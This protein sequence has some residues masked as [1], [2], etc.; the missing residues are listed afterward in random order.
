MIIWRP[1]SIGSLSTFAISWVSCFTRSKSRRP[2]SWLGDLTAAEAEGDLDLVAFLEEPLNGLH[3]HFV[4]VLVDAGTELDLLH[5]D[6]LLPLA[7]L[8]LL[9]LFVEAE[10]PVIKE[11]AD[12]RDRIRRDF[13]EVEADLLSHGQRVEEGHDTPVLPILVDE[14]DVADAAYVPVCAR[15]V[16]LRGRHGSHWS[17]NGSVL[18]YQRQNGSLRATASGEPRPPIDP[19]LPDG[20]NLA[21]LLAESTRGTDFGSPCH[22]LALFRRSA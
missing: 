3:L 6:R 13:D 12:G 22:V 18:L 10:A 20:T 1:S 9:L 4:I 11:L 8:V 16:L 21:N 7:G 19:A 15:P 14:L 2:I 17:A 5:L